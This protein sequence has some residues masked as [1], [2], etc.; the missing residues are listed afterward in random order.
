[1]KPLENKAQAEL[2]LSESERKV[3]EEQQRLESEKKRLLEKEKAELE[4]K[5]RDEKRK[6][7]IADEKKE[8]AEKEEKSLLQPN[9][10]NNVIEWKRKGNVFEGYYEDCLIFQAIPKTFTFSLKITNRNI[11]DYLNENKKSTN[12]NSTGLFTLQRK[13]NDILLEFVSR[14]QKL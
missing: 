2:H 10:K 3:K 8:K 7:R 13:A 14:S 1:M 5:I 6:K 4:Q 11:V 12:V 9:I